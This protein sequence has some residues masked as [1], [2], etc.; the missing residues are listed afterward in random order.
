MTVFDE[1]TIVSAT[2]GIADEK[3]ETLQDYQILKSTTTAAFNVM[4]QNNSIVFENLKFIGNPDSNGILIIKSEEIRTSSPNNSIY[5]KNYEFKIKIK[6]RKCIR[7]EYDN[8]I[9]KTCDECQIGFYSFE[10]SENCNKCPE[11]VAYCSKDI[12]DLRPG[13]WR[14]NENSSIIIEC[15][16]GID[17]CLGGTSW[18]DRICAEGT[19]G[20]LCESCDLYG[21]HWKSSYTKS[22][23]SCYKCDNEAL[24]IITLVF[25]SIMKVIM[26]ALS[27][28]GTFELTQRDTQFRL[29]RRFYAGGGENLFLSQMDLS[30]VY[31]KIFVNYMQIV[32]TC[33][34]L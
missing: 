21:R 15:S 34:H 25:V 1:A 18:G 16:N 9:S 22:D 19:I 13:Y 8:P 10:P 23:S 30:G 14:H 27:I 12:L 11:N 24:N 31:I 4:L 3:S 6:F 20:A 33:G 7:G 29:L 32:G 5:D 17:N 26:T 2:I 28:K